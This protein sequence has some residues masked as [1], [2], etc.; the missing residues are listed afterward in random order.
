MKN[1][2]FG[3]ADFIQ[4]SNLCFFIKILTCI[5]KCRSFVITKNAVYLVDTSTISNF[6]LR[7]GQGYYKGRMCYQNFNLYF[8]MQIFAI[9]KNVYLGDISTISNF[10]LRTDQGYYKSRMHLMSVSNQGPLVQPYLMSEKKM[11]EKKESK[12]K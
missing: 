3:H 8:Q 1:N 5:S 9:T 12:K 7:A 10:L 4:K 6:L 11:S 2:R